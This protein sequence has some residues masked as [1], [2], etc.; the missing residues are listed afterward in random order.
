MAG[1]GLA[2]CGAAGATCS[3]ALARPCTPHHSLNTL[4][5][6]STE[7]C[8][9]SSDPDTAWQTEVKYMVRGGTCCGALAWLRSALARPDQSL[10]PPH[11]SAAQSHCMRR[12]ALPRDCYDSRT[13]DGICHSNTCPPTAPPLHPGR[14]K[15]RP[16]LSCPLSWRCPPRS[17]RASLECASGPRL[18]TPR[19]A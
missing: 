14:R 9:R 11:A 17:R 8:I 4:G 15:S 19:A 1:R 5:F 13:G 7:G 6:G 18:R 2:R 3:R 10:T 16:T 12:T